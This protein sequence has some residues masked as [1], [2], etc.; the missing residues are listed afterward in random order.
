MKGQPLLHLFCRFVQIALALWQLHSKGILHRDLKSQNIFIAEGELGPWTNRL[1]VLQWLVLGARGSALQ[2]QQQLQGASR[3][4]EGFVLCHVNRN[5]QRAL[6]SR[7][8]AGA[9]AKLGDFGISR[10][11]NSETELVKTAV[12][13][14]QHVKH[15]SQPVLHQPTATSTRSGSKDSCPVGE[16][17]AA[18]GHKALL[19]VGRRAGSPCAA[20]CFPDRHTILPVA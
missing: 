3:A 9:I 18:L 6:T 19:G 4:H 5:N 8:P 17:Q 14:Q 1:D 11:L 13:T 2:E 16:L 15:C 7:C 10:V 20:V 12:S